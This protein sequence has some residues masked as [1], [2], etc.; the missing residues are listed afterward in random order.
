MINEGSVGR[1]GQI[2]VKLPALEVMWLEAPKSATQL[3]IA[4]G[5]IVMVWNEWASS[6]WSEELIHGVH[7]A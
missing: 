5:T 2:K 1:G 4:R 3:V 6:C 7:T